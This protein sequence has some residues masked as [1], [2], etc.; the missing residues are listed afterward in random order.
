MTAAPGL[1]R[2][3]L[4]RIY[5]A[6]NEIMRIDSIDSNQDGRWFPSRE[7]MAVSES[8]NIDDVRWQLWE[9]SDGIPI[10]IEKRDDENY[11]WRIPDQVQ[12]EL[13]CTVRFP[14]SSMNAEIFDG[15]N[16]FRELQLSYITGP[17]PLAEAPLP[18]DRWI[19]HDAE[20]VSCPPMSENFEENSAQIL[21]SGI[22]QG[23]RTE[24]PELPV[25]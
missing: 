10:A 18:N 25:G 14:G 1:P 11:Y 15:P 20:V 12:T 4:F 2:W 8:A 24:N 22:S 13:T 19:T 7:T 21:F 16:E 23:S 6:D 9:I 5:P 17:H 3:S